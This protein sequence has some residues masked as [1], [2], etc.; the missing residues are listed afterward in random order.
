[1]R[2]QFARIATGKMKDSCP[3]RAAKGV[4]GGVARG[5]KLGSDRRRE[6]AQAAAAA[7]WR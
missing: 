1:M 2:R 6:I 4:A 7:R 3:E 5:I